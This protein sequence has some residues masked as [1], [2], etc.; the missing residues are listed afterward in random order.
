LKVGICAWNLK[1]ELL[2]SIRTA[3]EL[4]AD[5]VQLM[6]AGGHF[7]WPPDRQTMDRVSA[8]AGEAGVEIASFAGGFGNLAQEGKL[9]E[10]L[11]WAK[12]VV[13]LAGDMGVGIVTSHVGVIPDDLDSPQ[14][15]AMLSQLEKLGTE[16]QQR[17]LK[18]G[19]ETGPEPPETMAAAL[20]RLSIPA[21]GVNYDP[22]NLLMAGFDWLGGVN[23]LAPWIVHVHAKDARLTADGK[24]EQVPFGEGDVDVPAF[25]AALRQVGFDGYATLERESGEER[26]RDM[27]NGLAVLRQ[28]V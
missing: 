14:G 3:G 2:Q 17:G 20:G 18:M 28:Y 4:G 27:R 23:V 15:A 21:L 6:A 1:Q 16:A 13:A 5:C 25:I 22:A 12:S 7:P 8:A 10:R 24:P 9:D 11:D 26:L 19:M